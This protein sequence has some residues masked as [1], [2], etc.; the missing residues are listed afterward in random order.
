VRLVV[1]REREAGVQVLLDIGLDVLADG[2]IDGLLGGDTCGRGS[3]LGLLFGEELPGALVTLS[4]LFTCEE[5]IVD[6]GDINTGEGDGGGG[7]DG[8]N[9]VDALKRDTVDLVGSGDQEEAGVESLE[10]N[11]ALST[12]TTGEEDENATGFEALAELGGVVHLFAGI[13]RDLVSWIPLCLFD[14]WS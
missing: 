13:T 9:L 3:G 2:A 5:G 8:V 12:E 7:G 10:H 11:D 4:A 6:L 14:H 1:N